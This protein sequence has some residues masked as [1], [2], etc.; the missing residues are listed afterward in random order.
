MELTGVDW[1]VGWRWCESDRIH[2]R[3]RTRTH[4]HTHTWRCK[5]DRKHTRTGTH[6]HTHTNTHTWRWED[7]GMHARRALMRN[8]SDRDR[9]RR[10]NRSALVR[11]AS[12]NKGEAKLVLVHLLSCHVAGE[13]AC[14]RYNACREYQRRRGCCL[15]GHLSCNSCKQLQQPA[16][17]EPHRNQ[18]SHVTRTGWAGLELVP[19]GSAER[20]R[21][22]LAFVCVCAEEFR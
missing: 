17:V 8:M 14:I 19:R 2:T 4:T 11:R 5:G 18:H 13:E 21:K 1:E 16:P 15:V 20:R 7:D 12:F 6:A 9:M 22:G 10:Q 3:T